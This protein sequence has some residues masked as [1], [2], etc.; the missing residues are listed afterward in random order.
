VN[1]KKDPPI[2]LRDRTDEI[3][4]DGSLGLYDPNTKRIIIFDKGI[5]RAAEILMASQDDLEQIVRL[6]E[7]AHALLHLGLERDE[8]LTAMLSDSEWAERSRRRDSWFNALDLKVN[9]AL[10]QLLVRDGLRWL[11]L[12]ARSKTLRPRLTEFRMYSCG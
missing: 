9:E 6:H 8:C 12:N 7:W 10:A 4:I 11:E 2:R 5:K 1:L 3:V